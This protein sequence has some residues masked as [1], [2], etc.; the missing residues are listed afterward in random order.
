VSP[1]RTV[2]FIMW[3]FVLVMRL[4]LFGHV[5]FSFLYAVFCRC[6]ICRCAGNEDIAP[7]VW[8]NPVQSTLHMMWLNSCAEISKPISGNHRPTTMYPDSD[9]TADQ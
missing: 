5:A 9:E 1:L 8:L 3:C 2:R 7:S 4:M 6:P